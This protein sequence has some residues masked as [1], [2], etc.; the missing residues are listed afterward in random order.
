M[1]VHYEGYV[2][3]GI[4]FRV[5]EIAK[6]R[7]DK[8]F[9]HDYPETMAFCPQTGK[10]LWHENYYYVDGVHVSEKFLGID[11]P[12]TYS[13]DDS[14]SN[15]ETIAFVGKA[16]QSAG[17]WDSRNRKV[18]PRFFRPE[19]VEEIKKEL[20]EKLAPYSLWH[21]ERFGIYPVRYAG[22]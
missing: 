13:C 22:G 8:A 4:A 1:G 18:P 7:K 12:K 11:Y 6:P 21:E 14:L 19:E 3:I 17:D 16:L 15:P 10:K 2:V 20:K 9:P 5:S